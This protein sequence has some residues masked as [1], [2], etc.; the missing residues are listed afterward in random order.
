MLLHVPWL[1]LP[2]PEWALTF[3]ASLKLTTAG[4]AL[5]TGMQLEFPSLPVQSLI[6]SF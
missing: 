6:R 1:K 3:Q 5:L 2:E 4:N